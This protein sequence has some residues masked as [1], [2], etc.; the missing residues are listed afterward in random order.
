MYADL[1]SFLAAFEHTPGE[2]LRVQETVDP[3][4]EVSAVLRAAAPGGEGPAVLFESLAGY[5]G[6]RLAGNVLG[7]RR[8]AAELLGTDPRHLKEI[9]AARKAQ[10]MA[11]RQVR[12]AEV[13]TVIKEG[14]VDLRATL[15]VPTFHEGDA[16]P[17]FTAGIVIARDPESGRQNMGLHRMQVKDPDRLSLFLANPPLSAYF[18]R[19]E[20]AGRPLPVAVALGPDP[21][22]LMAAVSRANVDGQDK[23]ELAGGLRG[24]P[25]PVVKALTSEI[26]V[27]AMAEVIIEGEVIPGIREDEGPFGESTGY[28]FTGHSPVVRVKAITHRPSPIFQAIQPWGSDADILLLLTSGSE[29][30]TRLRELA[31]AVQDVN[32]VPGTCT[33]QAIISVAGA[34]QTEVRRIIHLALNMDRRLKQVTVVDDDVDIYDLREVM[35]ALATRF[36]PA[37]DTV[38]LTGLEGYVIDPSAVDGRTSKLGLDA[39]KPRGSGQNFAKIAVPPAAAARAAAILQ[40]SRHNPQ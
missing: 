23:M 39:T 1:R 32:L 25:V 2:L 15:P 19:A 38:V 40:R 6:W 26:L 28:Y 34:S 21:T 13:Q 7:S 8:R 14:G 36:Q 10:A 3:C 37:E 16:G 29:L 5:P 17:F 35:W 27:P 4:H 24:E 12:D 22:V 20:A 30:L 31:P 33:F 11:P 18:A 9:F